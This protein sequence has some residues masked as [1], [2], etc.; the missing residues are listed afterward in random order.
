MSLMDLL[1]RRR[2]RS[3]ANQMS[4]ASLPM[5]SAEPMD[6]SQED[7]LAALG[8]ES[9]LETGSPDLES[10]AGPLAGLA[11]LMGSASMDRPSVR[12]AV[13]TKPSRIDPSRFELTDVEETLTQTPPNLLASVR[14]K[15][16]NAPVTARMS[17]TGP[18]R[19]SSLDDLYARMAQS[20]GGSVLSQPLDKQRLGG[21]KAAE[22]AIET[23]GLIGTGAA[24]AGPGAMVTSMGEAAIPAST[25]LFAA[26]RAPEALERLRR[27]QEFFQRYKQILGNKSIDPRTVGR[28]QGSRSVQDALQRAL[29]IMGEVK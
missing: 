23:M 22:R 4:D 2:P 8:L 14:G 27:A 5:G 18:Q 6:L 13:L 16:R 3:F 15:T 17:G 21:L 19:G 28:W 25:R 9:E 12:E 7:L 1:R 29:E 10:S 24:Y 20:K 26:A 11:G